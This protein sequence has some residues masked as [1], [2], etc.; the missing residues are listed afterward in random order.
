M[1]PADPQTE[2]PGW[3]AKKE[4]KKQKKQAAREADSAKAKLA[5]KANREARN[6]ELRRKGKLTKKE[7]YKARKA[8][9]KAEALAQVE[10]A[11]DGQSKPKTQKKQLPCA[12][13]EAI[14]LAASGMKELDP[15]AVQCFLTGLPYMATEKHVA[16]HFASI[17]SCAVNL[18]CD[19]STGRSTGTG[20]VTFETAQKALRACTF[21]GTKIQN[22][23]I[24][25]RLC[26]VRENKRK[27]FSP[28]DGPG[29]KPEGCLSAVVKCDTSVTEASLK[30][31]FKDCNVVGVSRM[32]DNETGEFRGMAFLD[33]EDTEMVDKAVKKSGQTI[34]GNPCYVRYKAEKKA[35][36]ATSASD[37][38]PKTGGR[39]AAHNRA[40]P[41]PAP[42][43]TVTTFD[44]D[45]D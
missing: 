10:A 28:E 29:E 37:D 33:F 36:L 41:V 7:I 30:R 40:P 45:S 44:S 42:S 25:I 19:E 43:G 13:L 31:F 21:S 5:E 17:G 4:E 38:K 20:F 9:K 26:D 18:I 24:N 3:R 32:L 6:K 23:W 8:A 2:T 27:A 22:R 15:R 14:A 35:K 11:A 16:D 12:G 34:K 39:V 1:E